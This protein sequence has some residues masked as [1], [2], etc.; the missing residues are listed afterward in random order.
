MASLCALMSKVKIKGV[1]KG[2]VT[3]FA[4]STKRIPS[5]F[6]HV[7]ALH[8]Q[9]DSSST[10]KSGKGVNQ[11]TP[12]TKSIHFVA[13][14]PY[15]VNVANV[16]VDYHCSYRVIALLLSMEEKS[17]AAVSRTLKN[18]VNGVM[19][20]FNCLKVMNNINIWKTQFL[21]IRCL[22]YEAIIVFDVLYLVCEGVL[23]LIYLGFIAGRYK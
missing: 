22:W 9:H 18:L 4:R 8:A 17:W 7:D 1:E 15:I 10:W 5:Y 6:E 20:M 19:N 13:F 2:C 3:K 23:I 14:H 12:E 21:L 11:E 16:Q